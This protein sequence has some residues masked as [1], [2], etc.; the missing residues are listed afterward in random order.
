MRVFYMTIWVE[1][2][3]SNDNKSVKKWDLDLIM[4]QNVVNSVTVEC[5]QLPPKSGC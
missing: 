2:S 3:N 1:T 4:G 5:N